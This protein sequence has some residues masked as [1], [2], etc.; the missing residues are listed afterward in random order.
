MVTNHMRSLKKGL[1]ELKESLEKD[2]AEL[3]GWCVKLTGEVHELG[4]RVSHLEG[5]CKAFH[6]G[7]E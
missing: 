4:E 1:A 2:C 7:G 6:D 3:K 5:R